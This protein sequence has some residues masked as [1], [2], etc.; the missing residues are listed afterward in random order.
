MNIGSIKINKTDKETI[1]DLSMNENGKRLDIDYKYNYIKKKAKKYNEEIRLEI[2]YLVKNNNVLTLSTTI[3]NKYTDDISIK[4]DTTES[5]LE[6]SLT[7]EQKDRKDKF[8]ENKLKDILGG[9][10]EEKEK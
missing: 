2:K 10:Y 1:I 6:K 3:S 9:L 7:E 8:L 5:I 4:E